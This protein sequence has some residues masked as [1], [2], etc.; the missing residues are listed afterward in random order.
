MI[1]VTVSGSTRPTTCPL[2]RGELTVE[3]SRTCDGCGTAYHRACLADLG[4]CGTLGCARR[5]QTFAP[6]V[7]RAARSGA[8]ASYLVAG[9]VVAATFLGLAALSL[10][11]AAVHAPRPTVRPVVVRPATPPTPVAPTPAPAVTTRSPTPAPSPAEAP[12]SSTVEVGPDDRRTRR[13]QALT[14]AAEEARSD[15]Q[16][17][18]LCE[19][20]AAQP[21]ARALVEDRLRRLDRDPVAQARLRL[22]EAL[23]AGATRE[24]IDEALRT[25]QVSRSHDG[26][27]LPLITGTGP[28]PLARE[29]LEPRLRA[30]LAGEERETARSVAARAYVEALERSTERDRLVTTIERL[31]AHPTATVDTA[32]WL[33][34]LDGPDPHEVARA[35]RRAFVAAGGDEVPDARTLRYDRPF[36]VRARELLRE[37]RAVL[38]ADDAA[39]TPTQRARA[40]LAERAARPR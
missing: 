37:A 32:L 21:W 12:P 16:L 20:G 38:A 28:S 22:R 6:P 11:G 26:E 1:Q 25:G 31:L 35:A 9:G 14:R 40:A 39:E 36:E 7:P 27:V 10:L 15:F 13:L 33:G 34:R 5:G 30:A 2:C 29:A 4:G 18:D 23:D 17:L 3:R 8:A 24:E 19:G